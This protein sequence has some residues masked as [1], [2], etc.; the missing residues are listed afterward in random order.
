MSR[1][2]ITT[3]KEIHHQIRGAKF[4][5]EMNMGHGFYQVPLHTQFRHYLKPF[6]PPEEPWQELAANH[7]GPTK[8]GKYLL[9]VVTG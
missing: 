4:Y 7:W 3:P 5:T 1:N 6:P 8:Y 2:H 9:V